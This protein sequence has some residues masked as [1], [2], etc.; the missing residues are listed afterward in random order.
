MNDEVLLE[1]KPKFNRWEIETLAWFSALLFVTFIIYAPIYPMREIL[2]PIRA[3][4]LSGYFFTL[5]VFG[6]IW[7]KLIAFLIRKNYEAITYKA[8][9]DRI[10]FEEDFINH[11]YTVIKMADIKKIY[12][13]Q[14]F[15]QR[16]VKLGTIHFVTIT[17]NL[18][19]QRARTEIKFQ[20]IENPENVYKTIKQLHEDCA[21]SQK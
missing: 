3:M 15:L 20:D 17:N 10:E 4:G 5:V 18:D 6:L 13:T 7:A 2:Y 11:Q 12:L 1:L 8:Y 19:Y 16:Q 9:R 21:M 14:N